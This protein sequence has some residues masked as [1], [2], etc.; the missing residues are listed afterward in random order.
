MIKQLDRR[1]TISGLKT[2][3]HD[4]DR[5]F[6]YQITFAA[7]S[8]LEQLSNIIGSQPYD[9]S[10]QGIGVRGR[11][12]HHCGACHHRLLPAGDGV[13]YVVVGGIR[14]EGMHIIAGSGCCLILDAD[15]YQRSG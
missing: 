5:F 6:G 7:R 1:L 8:P 2:R 10:S 15:H 12:G 4:G 11:G 14:G 9:G 3:R 13:M